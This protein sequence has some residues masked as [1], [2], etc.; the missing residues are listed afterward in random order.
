MGS[1]YTLIKNKRN[2]AMFTKKHL[3][4]QAPPQAL[5]TKPGLNTRPGLNYQENFAKNQAQTLARR[6]SVSSR[7]STAMTSGKCGPPM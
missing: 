2:L 1:E 3:A 7:P 6:A 5:K 4:G